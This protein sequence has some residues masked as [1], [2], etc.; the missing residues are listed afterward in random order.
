MAE[1]QGRGLGVP[2]VSIPAEEAEAHFGWFA[3]FAGADLP[4]S[5]LTRQKLGWQPVGPVMLTD[6]EGMDYSQ[7]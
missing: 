6:L 5:S 2:T 4:S 7:A 1:A 3:P